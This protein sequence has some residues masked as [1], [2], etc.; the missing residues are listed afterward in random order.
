[1][2]DLWIALSKQSNTASVME[3]AQYFS[4]HEIWLDSMNLHETS[5][6]LFADKGSHRNESFGWPGIIKRN[7]YG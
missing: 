6:V 2:N 4:Y 7:R 1:M 3:R 5:W